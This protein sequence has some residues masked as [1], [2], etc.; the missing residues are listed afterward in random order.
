MM[1]QKL[2]RFFILGV[3]FTI[4]L[5][6][7]N[8]NIV[9]ADQKKVLIIGDSISQRSKENIRQKVSGGNSSKWSTSSEDGHNHIEA[10]FA[11]VTLDATDGRKFL[12]G[13]EI[14][15]QKYKNTNFDTIIIELGTNDYD[16]SDGS[17]KY[18][19]QNDVDKFISL[20]D[21]NTK[22]YFVTN[23][24]DSIGEGYNEHNNKFFNTA[25]RK[26]SNVGILD[27]ASIATKNNILE[28]GVHPTN[29]GK[30]LLANLY[31]GVIPT[32]TNNDTTTSTSTGSSPGS[33]SNSQ[34]KFMAM[35]GVYYYDPFG[36]D[37]TTIAIGSYSGTASAGLTAAQ[38]GFVDTYHDIAE[39][40]SIEFGIPWEAVMAQ[41]ILESDAGRSHFATT[42]NNFF[43][44]AA[45]DSNT[46]AAY[47]YETPAAGWRGYYTNIVRT[48][49]Y[50]NHGV[51][52]NNYTISYSPKP[53]GLNSTIR[54]NITNPFSY[55]QT[56]WDSGYATDSN[57]YNKVAKFIPAIINRANE[58]GWMT[59]EALAQAH[60]EML[61]NAAAN[62]AGANNTSVGSAQSSSICTTS[63]QGN[64]DIN[65]TAINLAWPDRSNG[66]TPKPTYKTA[67]QNIGLWTGTGTCEGIGAA[68]DR[69]VTTVMRYSGVDPNFASG[70]AASLVDYMSTSSLYEEI[71]NIGNSSNLR[72]GDILG[73]KRSSGGSTG[74]VMFYVQKPDGS[75]GIASASKCDHSGDLASNYTPT[76]SISGQPW[77][78]F[79]YVGNNN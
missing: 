77:R 56:V 53:N 52:Q 58:H 57:Y 3:T 31:L 23:Y 10:Q 64:G 71:D 25:A 54:D 76:D 7:V 45:Y 21:P 33:L 30:N 18:L 19:T 51:F 27:W 46:G 24:Q 39:Q 68:C 2:K 16:K 4:L 22:I 20:I 5:G 43:G 9:F 41:G 65:S 62:A 38:A 69:F 6:L 29:A 49:T 78:I 70:S 32:N 63:G 55:L 72:P 1:R 60:P 73:V 67:L 74:H 17:R 75:Y 40:L 61:T 44:I 50:R 48:A 8:T 59:S 47:S 66:T 35:N 14:Y 28:D 12:R 11:N 13:L 34:L 42:R 15:E 36:N 26:Y 37:C 79:R